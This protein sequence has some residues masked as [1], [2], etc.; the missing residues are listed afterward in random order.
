MPDGF[1]EIYTYEELREWWDDFY[2]GAINF[3]ALIGPRGTGKS[4]VAKDY[5]TNRPHLY[6]KGVIS[7]RGLYEMLFQYRDLPLVFDDVLSLLSNRDCAAT[8][9]SVCDRGTKFV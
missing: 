8:V 9:N 4:T 7:P 5:M 2:G 1:K 3:F 6:H